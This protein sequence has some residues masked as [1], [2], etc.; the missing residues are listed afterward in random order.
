MR[1][2]RF[3]VALVFCWFVVGVSQETTQETKG[4]DSEVMVNEQITPDDTMLQRGLE[5]YLKNACG[6]CHT[7]G[8]AG[9]RGRFGPPHDGSALI[10]AARFQDPNY[11]GK[12]T[13]AQEYLLES[14]LEPQ[15]Y[16][17][18]GY[19]MSR[20]KMPAYINLN[21]EDIDA[22]VYLLSQP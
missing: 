7:Y 9:T 20:Y 15:V 18:P 14:L 1:C 12:A 17:V 22:L 5:L 6:V 13:T 4:A 16:I 2:F 10:A 3:V 19:G 11:T 21:Q 8:K